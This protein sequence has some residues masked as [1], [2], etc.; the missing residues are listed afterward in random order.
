M[1]GRNFK[2]DE[3]HQCLETDVYSAHG[4]DERYRTEESWINLITS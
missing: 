4:L 3:G 1:G 2:R